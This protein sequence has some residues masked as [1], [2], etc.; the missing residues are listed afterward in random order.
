MILGVVESSQQPAVH[1]L[2]SSMTTPLMMKDF[3]ERVWSAEALW[4]AP[5][6]SAA[7]V[8]NS[9]IPQH[10]RSAQATALMA[11]YN[12]T[13]G[14]SWHDRS[15]WG[16]G[17]P[18]STGG[19]WFGVCCK[20]SCTEVGGCQGAPRAQV[21]GLLLRGNGL[22]G[23]LPADPEVW[24]ALSQIQTLSLRSNSLSGPIPAAISVLADSLINLNLRRNVLTGPIPPQLGQLRRSSSSGDT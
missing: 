13:G 15:G 6:G 16:V 5:N 14:A 20:E 19:G 18:C 1:Q 21:T 8:W 22:R 4:N 3:W 7:R 23:T 12:A 2:S 17:D 10:S 24:S 11:I 9:V